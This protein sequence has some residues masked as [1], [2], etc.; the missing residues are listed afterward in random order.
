MT[1]LQTRPESDLLRNVPKMYKYAARRFVDFLREN[2]LSIA[3][4]ETWTRYVDELEGIQQTGK[5][6]GKR[7]AAS[8][9][10][11]HISAAVERLKYVMDH[12]DLTVKQKYDLEQ[13][14][15]KIERPKIKP[16]PVT[17]DQVLSEE[18]IRLFLEKCRK[19]H[20]ALMFE[21][22]A[23][24]GLRVSE[25]LGITLG[26]MKR[27]N[28]HYSVRI[29]GKGNAE[30]IIYA[31]TELVERCKE[32]FKPRNYLFRS[33]QERPYDRSYVSQN[34]RRE[35]LRI[36]DRPISAHSLRHSYATIV[37]RKTGRI[38]ALQ[39]QLGHS[40]ASTTLNFYAKDSFSW[41]EQ[42]NFFDF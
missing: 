27:L 14:I 25:M 35:A 34:I 38:K 22:L 5:M 20:I 11:H 8:T 32:F 3:E 33:P 40:S 15:K 2:D 1:E 9:R 18:E 26:D 16:S 4:P 42:E 39:T 41:E 37:L 19:P 21:F 10:N 29:H 28:G 31:P 36:L 17:K 24:T 30:R 13:M 7:Y 6:K 12:S 23:K